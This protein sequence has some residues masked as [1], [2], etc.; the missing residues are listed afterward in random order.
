MHKLWLFSLLLAFSQMSYAQN[1]NKPLA[2]KSIYTVIDE[3]EQALREYNYEK[4]GQLFEDASKIDIFITKKELWDFFIEQSWNGNFSEKINAKRIATIIS[5]DYNLQFVDWYGEQ[6]TLDLIQYNL[7]S[8][9]WEFKDDSKAIDKFLKSLVKDEVQLI[10]I[11]E[12]HLV[13]YR[14]EMSSI[15][16]PSSFDPKKYLET[17]INAAKDNDD[18]AKIYKDAARLACLF[19]KN[20]EEAINWAQISYKIKA[21]K[22]IYYLLSDIYR[23]LARQ[24]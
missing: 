24:K 5:K 3:L 11:R 16:T 23:K 10:Y 13:G 7:S 15:E 12:S 14:H 18:K 17:G 21:D 2:E 4:A 20:I 6:A 22:D 9:L 8:A 19:D 1:N